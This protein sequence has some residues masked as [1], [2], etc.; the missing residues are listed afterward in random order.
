MI[1]ELKIRRVIPSE[2]L[3][4]GAE[5]PASVFRSAPTADAQTT[6]AS[7]PALPS[8]ACSRF[9]TRHSHLHSFTSSLGSLVSVRRPRITLRD[10]R[11]TP[12]LL[13]SFTSSLAPLF[14]WSLVPC[15]FTPPTFAPTCRSTPPLPPA[16][17]V[18]VFLTTNH[19][20][21]TTAFTPPPHQI[22]PTPPSIQTHPPI[23]QTPP[24]HASV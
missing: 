3:L 17:A 20:P 1:N 9:T 13:Y 23:L 14:P 12:P 16:S 11:F 21:L 7:S 24:P 6:P 19:Y 5:E 2:A 4:S 15:S 8:I 18:G 22:R 10:P